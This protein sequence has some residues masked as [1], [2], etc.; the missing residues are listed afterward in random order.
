MTTE[1]STNIVDNLAHNN[2]KYKRYIRFIMVPK[3]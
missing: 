3:V 1:L 2:F